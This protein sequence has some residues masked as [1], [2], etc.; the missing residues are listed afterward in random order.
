MHGQQ[1]TFRS[2]NLVEYLHSLVSPH[3]N[4]Y[5]V[6]GLSFVGRVFKEQQTTFVWRLVLHNL[7]LGAWAFRSNN[8]ANPVQIVALSSPVRYRMSPVG[9]H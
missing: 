5:L 3:T 2:N 6:P 9:R 7:A 1:R 8:L 4:C